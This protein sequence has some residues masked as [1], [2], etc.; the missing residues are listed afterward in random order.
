MANLHLKYGG[1]AVAQG[2]MDV[3]TLAP[4]LISFGDMAKEVNRIVNGPKQDIKI[5][6]QS[7]FKHGSFGI[8]F[9]MVISLINQAKS[10]FNTQ[11]LF[12]GAGGV[13]S[14]ITIYW[15]VKKF[16]KGQ[17]PKEI[18]KIDRST[19][20]NIIN[21]NSEKIEVPIQI[22]KA[23]NNKKINNA[24]EG[25]ILR[26][27]QETGIESVD[28]FD[29]EK[30]RRETVTSEEA[31]YF[32]ALESKIEEELPPSTRT[33]GVTIHTLS[34]ETNRWRFNVSGAVKWLEIL[35]EAFLQRVSSSKESFRSGD[36]LKVNI[37]TEQVIV[38][39]KLETKETITKVI[40]HIVGPEQESMSF[41]PPE[42]H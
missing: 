12:V 6:I 28:L 8:D 9:E 2:T 5:N 25:I 13:A 14:F 39:S 40:K 42:E 29:I 26:P 35:D 33:I 3:Y 41:G 34:W 20:I 30:Q 4:A 11:A 22:G 21:I 27:L 32:E 19:N 37:L 36:I 38:D 18:I 1:P 17:K 10:L 23:I 16:L 24:L 15:G 31:S 7:D